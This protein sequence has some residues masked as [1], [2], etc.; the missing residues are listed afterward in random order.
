MNIYLD[1]FLSFLK[2]S[3]FTVGGGYAMIPFIQSTVLSKGWISPE[4]LI[5]FI[6][7]AE[8][9]PGPF[10]VNISTFIGYNLG[11]FFGVICAILGLFLPPFLIIIT[12][13]YVGKKF[14][15]N[16]IVKGIFVFLRPA[17]LAL[18]LSAFSSVAYATIMVSD[19]GTTYFNWFGVILM[20]ASFISM[21]FFK[22]IH[23]IVFLFASAGLGLIFYGFVL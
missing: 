2:I 14:S 10:A 8:S 3:L 17:V 7:I 20:F 22:K 5:N 23:P 19:G 6:G 1:L 18:I 15:S 21:R 11:G 12:I 4:L 9:T 13:F 16:K